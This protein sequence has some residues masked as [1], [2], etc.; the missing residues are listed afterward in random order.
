MVSF[1]SLPLHARYPVYDLVGSV[2][3]GGRSPTERS[4]LARLYRTSCPHRD[5]PVVIFHRTTQATRCDVSMLFCTTVLQLIGLGWVPNPWLAHLLVQLTSTNL[6][7][8]AAPS[9][10]STLIV[11]MLIQY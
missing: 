2:L 10:G 4:E 8:V 7:M 6:P 3:S 1:R 9:S 5:V 11:S